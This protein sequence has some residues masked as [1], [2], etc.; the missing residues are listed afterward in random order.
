MDGDTLS[1][2]AR[3]VVVFENRSDGG[4]R[5]YSDDVPGFIL[6]HADA[7]AVMRD[8]KP[9]LEVII[10]DMVGGPVVVEPIGRSW[11][12]SDLPKGSRESRQYETRRAA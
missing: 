3:I 4:L 8:V 6:S 7:A 2:V 10:A 12:A 11:A 9:A 5:A 1:R